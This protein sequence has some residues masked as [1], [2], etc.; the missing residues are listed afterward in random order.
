[1]TE[2]NDTGTRLLAILSEIGAHAVLDIGCG[3]GALA[4]NLVRAGYNV[5]GI[6]PAPEA[7][8]AARLSVPEARFEACGAEALPF[9]AASFQACVFLNSLH[10]VPVPLMP[11]ALRE[12]LRV[13]RPGGEVIIVEPLAEGAFFEV[14]RP[15]EDETAIRH[16]AI[17]AIDTMLATGEATGPAPV[18]YARPTPVADLDAFIAY[19][20]RVDPARRALAEAQRE[21]LGRLYAVH[22]SMGS[23][24]P[25]LIQPLR[26]WRLRAA[27]P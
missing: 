27:K 22:V 24:G 12:A 16:A 1:M 4:R 3:H 26:L 18:T 14:M 25:E 23:N 9:A 19:L 5:T 7:V 11:D 2:T 21:T 20:A 17:R 6:D 10:H 15:V 13:L 8:A